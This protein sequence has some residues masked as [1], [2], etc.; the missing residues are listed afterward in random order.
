MLARYVLNDLAELLNL[1]H[2]N[3]S[4]FKMGAKLLLCTFRDSMKV[5]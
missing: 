5:W 1:S 4:V 3:L 2:I